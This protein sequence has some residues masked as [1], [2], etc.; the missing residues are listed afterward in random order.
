MKLRGKRKNLFLKNYVLSCVINNLELNPMTNYLKLIISPSQALD[1]FNE[2]KPHPLTLYL[3]GTITLAGLSLPKYI[4]ASI[5]NPKG[6]EALIYFLVVVPF[7][8][9][10]FSYGSGYLFLI[11]SKG[12]KGVS[13]YTEMRNLTVY[14]IMPFILQFVISI[15][16]ITFGLIKNNAE[17]ITHD[18]YLSHII[19][20]LLSF[21]IFMVGIAKYNKFNWTI[22]LLTY[23]I[24]MSVVGGFAFLLLQLRK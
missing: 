16:F 24:V 22:T 9:F 12:F 23:F 13:T 3:I 17:M 4:A 10:P 19:L 11:V 18:N 2:K 5:N 20:W 15:P 6:L 1:N 14:S 7:V 21:R 8:Y